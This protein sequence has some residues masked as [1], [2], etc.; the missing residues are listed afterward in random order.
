MRSDA[1]QIMLN[2]ADIA[3]AGGI[4][5]IRYHEN[6]KRGLGNTVKAADL[7][8]WEPDIQGA[9][10]EL[11]V[12]KWLDLFWDGMA[13]PTEEPDVT[14]VDVRT[15]KHGGGRLAIY[16]RDLQI[17]P[18]IPYVLVV[19][20]LPAMYL[21]GWRFANEVL[22]PNDWW[23]PFGFRPEER[24]TKR[25]CWGIPQRDLHAMENLEFLI[26]RGESRRA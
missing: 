6:R 1:Q 16:K 8:H 20:R 26:G 14:F 10:G 9:L 23:K 4:A 2:D 13:D 22:Q 18:N 12:S 24:D 25:E 5:D 17:K 21:V 19:Q 3:F 15:T 7:D 11:A